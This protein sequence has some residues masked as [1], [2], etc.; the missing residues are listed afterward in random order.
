MIIFL[1]KITEVS[2]VFQKLFKKKK[3]KKARGNSGMLLDDSWG[4]GVLWK[5][6]LLSALQRLK[7]LLFTRNKSSKQFTVELLHE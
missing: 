2:F 1:S 7:R 6:L 5:L 4:M 3:E